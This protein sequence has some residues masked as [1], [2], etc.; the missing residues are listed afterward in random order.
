MLEQVL[1]FATVGRYIVMALGGIGLILLIMGIYK[2]DRER[3]L[4]GGYLLVFAIVVWVCAQLL[5]SVTAD[6]AQQKMYQIQQQY[7][8]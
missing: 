7:G 2:G 4:K 3:M 1:E 8:Y 5:F 6:R